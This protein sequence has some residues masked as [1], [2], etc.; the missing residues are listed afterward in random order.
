MHADFGSGTWD[1]GPIG[2]P[3]DFVSGTQPLASINYTAYGDES[4]AGPF[5][6]PTDAR[7]EGGSGSDGDRHVLVVNQDSCILYEL[8]NAF[9][10]SDGS[11]NADSGARYDLKTNAPLRTSGWTSAD[12]AGLPIA[13]GLVTYD[14]VASGEIKNAIRFTVPQTRR[15]YVWPARHFASDL[16]GAQYPPMGQRFRLKANFPISNFAPEVQVILRALKKYGM[17]V[18]DNGSSW[19]IS[20]SPDERWNNDNLHQLDNSVPGSAFEA[21][22]SN[23]LMIG[24]SSGQARNFSDFALPAVY[25]ERNPHILYSG[26]WVNVSSSLY[27]SRTLKYSTAINSA[28]LIYFK[29]N[30]IS[31]VYAKAPTYGT[32]TIQIDNRPAIRINQYASRKQYRLRWTS[33]VLGNAYHVIKLT[34]TSGRYTSLDSITVL[35]P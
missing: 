20:G 21:V 25:D 35:S 9:P 31:I 11:W 33:S 22:F 5:P 1:G 32:V 2:F 15:A 14:E 17:I 19:Y 24:Q 8:Y 7:V 27:Y 12:A 10:Q 6:I 23:A 29:G 26:K 3:V 16:T 28:A 18:A 4:D 13:P 30:R 34:H